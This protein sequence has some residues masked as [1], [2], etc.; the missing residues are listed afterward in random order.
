MSGPVN[1]GST[2]R[3]TVAGSCGAPRRASIGSEIKHALLRVPTRRNGATGAQSA[4][5]RSQPTTGA[6]RIPAPTA[7]AGVADP[8]GAEVAI[9]GLETGRSS[10]TRPEFARARRV[11]PPWRPAY[12]MAS[13]RVQRLAF[14]MVGTAVV[15]IV[16]AAATV[17]L[18]GL[19]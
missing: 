19:S 9:A 2:A 7:H 14:G 10:E 16:A 1:G 13:D 4:T 3:I 12:L 6:L 15:A 17:I 8:G 5:R 11:G 18:R